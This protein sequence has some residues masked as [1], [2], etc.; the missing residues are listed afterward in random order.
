MANSIGRWRRGCMK[1]R[2][3]GRKSIVYQDMW[4]KTFSSNFTKIA[5][6]ADNGHTE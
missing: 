6:G 3:G 1:D 5:P 2:G 4:M